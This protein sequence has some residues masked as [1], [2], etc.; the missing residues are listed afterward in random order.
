MMW[1]KAIIFCVSRQ[2]K[3]TAILV[4][5]NRL[6]MLIADCSLFEPNLQVGG[7]VISHL[8]VVARKKSIPV[9]QALNL[10]SMRSRE[11]YS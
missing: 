6:M 4:H 5:V 3:R 11:R 7:D 1:R 2:N 8:R 10:G 9:L